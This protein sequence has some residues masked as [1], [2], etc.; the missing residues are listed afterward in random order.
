MS[1][2]ETFR[3]FWTGEPRES[4][5][6]SYQDVWGSGR[7]WMPTEVWAGVPVN[8]DQAQRLS[9]VWRCID[10]ISGTLAGLPAE[11]VR[12]D[13]DIRTPVARPPGWLEY[14]NPETN[15]MEYV[16]R[17]LESLLLD[18]NAFVLI[19][20]RDA[21]MFPAELWTLNPADVTVKRENGRIFYIHGG[22]TTRPLSR[23]GPTNPGGDVM[24]IRLRSAG[25]VRGL[26]PIAY[27]RQAI[28]LGLVGEKFGSRFFGGGQ[29]MS[30][31]IEL[32]ADQPAK[33]R[34]HI[35]LMRQTWESA[36][37]GSDR[38]HR[39]GILTGGAKWTGITI[40]PED[41]QFLQTRA[42]QVEEIGTRFFGVP[43]NFI[44]LTEKQSSWGP[45]LEQQSIALLRYTLQTHILRLE[46]AHTSLVPRGQFLRLNPKRMLE[47]DMETEA[48]VLAQKLEHGVI[49]RN[50][51]RSFDDEPPVPGGDRYMIPGN[52]ELLEPDGTKTEP[53]PPAA[54]EPEPPP[55]PN[56]NGRVIVP[57]GG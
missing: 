46:W 25:G 33:S 20:S 56:G 26:S 23:Y 57:T 51:W 7:E 11:V 17:L 34:E 47:A 36:H 22:D 40:A 37:G 28:G 44:G 31:V 38:A 55:S 49:N 2:R 45:G 18:G 24:H 29:Q 39:P 9:V 54:S 1:I 8:Q 4:H 10:L 53:A 15:W 21:T 48:R 5:A 14:P 16:E 6:L 19:T 32:P 43:P 12:K 41:A 27:A 35:E 13:G 30:G 52:M 42:F 50:K 3:S